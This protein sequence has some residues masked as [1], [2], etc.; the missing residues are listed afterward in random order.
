MRT[1][2]HVID[3]DLRC[4]IITLNLEFRHL[5]HFI[6]QTQYLAW[7]KVALHGLIYTVLDYS[8]IWFYFYLNFEAQNSIKNPASLSVTT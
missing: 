7:K 6:Q 8:F 1:L 3:L 4:C 2:F 5:R